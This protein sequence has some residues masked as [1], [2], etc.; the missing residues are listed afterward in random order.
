MP[1][2]VENPAEI[3]KFMKEKQANEVD[4]ADALLKSFNSKPLIDELRTIVGVGLSE[5][6]ALNEMTRDLTLVINKAMADVM[7]DEFKNGMA[8][9]TALGGKLPKG[10]KQPM[11]VEL[12]AALP[13]IEDQLHTL[14]AFQCSDVIRLYGSMCEGLAKKLGKDGSYQAFM[15]FTGAPDQKAAYAAWQKSPAGK[16]FLAAVEKSFK[17][18]NGA[19]SDVKKALTHMKELDTLRD[20]LKYR[21]LEK[22]DPTVWDKGALAYGRHRVRQAKL[23]KDGHVVNRLAMG[24]VEARLAEERKGGA[25]VW[26]LLDSSTIGL[27]D[28]VFGLVPAS[29][30][31]GTTVDS[32]FFME[33]MFLPP[34]AVSP[35]PVFWMLPLATIVAGNHHSMIEV[36]IPLSTMKKLD[37]VNGLY[38]TLLPKGATLGASAIEA[39]LKKAEADPRNRHMLIFYSAKAKPAGCFLFEAGD[40]AAWKKLADAK[41]LHTSFGELM[42]GTAEKGWPKKAEIE[43]FIKAHAH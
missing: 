2:L 38:T 15:K 22:Q 25:T 17:D 21:D 28:R 14:D 27:M 19:I 5:L 34:S 39:A 31:S 12:P 37:Y 13:Q 4:L 3:E 35:D 1:K 41:T 43:A 29:D 10:A 23:D 8:V 20:G 40:L 18:A 30:I 42:K 36:A 26:K 6:I 9:L 24:E 33:K 32:T 7:K 11:K 16:E